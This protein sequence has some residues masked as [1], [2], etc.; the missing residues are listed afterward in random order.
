MSSLSCSCT[1]SHF[2][3]N[4][5]TVVNRTAGYRYT[6]LARLHSPSTMHTLTT[7]TLS[8]ARRSYTTALPIARERH[9]QQYGQV[10]S[11]Q[12]DL[13]VL[14]ALNGHGQSGSTSSNNN[15]T[16]HHHHSNSD[17]S[18]TP[19]DATQS[20][21]SLCSWQ[22]WQCGNTISHRRGDDNQKAPVN[23]TA[24]TTH[25]TNCEAVQPV[26]PNSTYFDILPISYGNTPTFDIDTNQLRRTFL[27]IQQRVHPDAYAR[28][29]ERERQLAE[30]QSSWLNHA[31]HTLRDPLTRAQYLLQLHDVDI[32][33]TESIADPELLMTVMQ[34]REDIEEAQNDT[35]MEAIAG[36]NN[37]RIDATI[38][39]LNKAFQLED[40][41]KA[42]DLAIELKYWY[43]IKNTIRLWEDKHH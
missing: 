18:T 21:S 30:Q 9:Q 2:Y 29:D 4:V 5:S 34:T 17:K 12:R 28:K 11:L 15:N 38:S 6:S 22:C 32:S 10:Q 24:V 36:E 37:I 13:A 31:Y 20:P 23:A 35:Q 19:L 42:K 33:E 39:E 40:I 16:H 3:R 7:T 1:F 43:R 8:S 41:T 27:M 14:R 26:P 25:C